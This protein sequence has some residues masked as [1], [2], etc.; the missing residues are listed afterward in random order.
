MKGRAR[1][2]CYLPVATCIPPPA[3][4]L[5]HMLPIRPECEAIHTPQERHLVVVA[6]REGAVLRR[7]VPNQDVGRR[8]QRLAQR[9]DRVRRRDALAQLIQA[10]L[11]VAYHHPRCQLLLRKALPLPIRP[12]PRSH[13]TRA[14]RHAT[15]PFRARMRRQGPRGA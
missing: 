13:V 1:A 10:Y 3:C 9:H 6:L 14:R 8:P 2:S 12:N 7:V 5:P 11:L 15:C 4:G